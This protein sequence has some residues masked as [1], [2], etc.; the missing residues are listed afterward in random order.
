M[1]GVFLF[2]IGPISDLSNPRAILIV[3]AYKAS[4]NYDSILRSV[5]LWKLQIL[6]DIQ[7]DF[8]KS[9]GSSNWKSTLRALIIS[10][11]L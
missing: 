4:H 2:L 3:N 5:L 8:D 6:V 7:V 10:K 1:F 11:H 9:M